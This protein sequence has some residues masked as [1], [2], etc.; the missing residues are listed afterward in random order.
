MRVLAVA[1]EQHASTCRAAWQSFLQ[2]GEHGPGWG[3]ICDT[4]TGCLVPRKAAPSQPEPRP[5][6]ILPPRCH[7]QS[8]RPATT[9]CAA[10]PCLPSHTWTRSRRSRPPPPRPAGSGPNLIP[11]RPPPGWWCGAGATPRW[12]RRCRGVRCPTTS[13]STPR[14]PVPPSSRVGRGPGALGSLAWAGAWLRARRPPALTPRCRGRATFEAAHP[15]L[16][17]L[18]EAQ[19]PT[20]L[21]RACTCAR[22]P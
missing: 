19:A 22:R 4:D 13:T 20:W 21:A 8:L 12:T 15:R 3:G 7:R 11:W 5:R 6:R 10:A 2:G 1:V 14:E 18:P 17:S 16:H 9:P